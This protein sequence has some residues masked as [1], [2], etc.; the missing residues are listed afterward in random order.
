MYTLYR[1][2][3]P[4]EMSLGLIVIQTVFCIGLVLQNFSKDAGAVVHFTVPFLKM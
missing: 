1:A 4:I 3:P 2:Q